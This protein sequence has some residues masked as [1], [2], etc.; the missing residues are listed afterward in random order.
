MSRLNRNISEV[1]LDKK[2]MN[3]SIK[4]NNYHSMSL[5]C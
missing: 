4:H 2:I 5:G 3:I 1:R